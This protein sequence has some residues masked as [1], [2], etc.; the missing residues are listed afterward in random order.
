MRA[1]LFIEPK[2]SKVTRM[3][4]MVATVRHLSY[5]E[6]ININNKNDKLFTLSEKWYDY[7]NYGQNSPVRLIDYFLLIIN[8]NDMTFN[9]Y[10][11]IINHRSSSIFY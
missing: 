3:L 1:L 6:Y 8:K 5:I 11:S 2:Y 10:K 7:R 4:N 9:L